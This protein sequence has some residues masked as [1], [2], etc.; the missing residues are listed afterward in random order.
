MEINQYEQ[1]LVERHAEKQGQQDGYRRRKR[2]PCNK[3][4]L[5]TLAKG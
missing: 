4:A 1:D 2:K 3:R 5:D